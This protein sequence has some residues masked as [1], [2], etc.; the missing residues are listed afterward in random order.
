MPAHIFPRKF[1]FDLRRAARSHFHCDFKQNFEI[2]GDSAR[3]DRHDDISSS[4]PTLKRLHD[5]CTQMLVRV[6]TIITACA[7]TRV[8]PAIKLDQNDILVGVILGPTREKEERGER[9]RK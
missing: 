4:C 2:E 6:Y 9:R 1:S 7:F 8:E 3:T 5:I